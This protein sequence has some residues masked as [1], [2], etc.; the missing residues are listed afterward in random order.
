MGGTAFIHSFVP[1]FIHSFIH[2]PTNS[3]LSLCLVETH[4]VGTAQSGV[5]SAVAEAAQGPG[6]STE[7]TPRP[8]GSS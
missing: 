6:G 2:S 5:V 7:E 1:S 8:A 4:P 3:L